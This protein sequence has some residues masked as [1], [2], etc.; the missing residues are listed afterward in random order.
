VPKIL[1]IL[2]KKEDKERM[3]EL[4]EKNIKEVKEKE[5]EKVKKE[6]IN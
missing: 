5:V 3:M 6:C 1:G 2:V 4:Y